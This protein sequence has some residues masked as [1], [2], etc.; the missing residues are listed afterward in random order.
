[1]NKFKYYFVLLIASITI[2]SCNKDKDEPEQVPLRDY[3]VQYAADKD[4]I[5][6][7]LKTNYIKEVTANFDITIEKIP[8]GGT[9][10]SIWEQTTYP[11]QIRKVYNNDVDYEVYYLILNKG[12]GQ[13][14][15]NSDRINASYTGTLLNGTQ[16]DSSYGLGR[17]FELYMNSSQAVIDGWGE[18]FPQFKTGTPNAA[19]PDGTITYKDYGAGVMFLP[20]GLAYYGGGTDNIPAYSPL[21]FSFKLFDLQRLDHDGD[22]V[23]DLNEDIN[24]DGYVYDL[25]NTTKFPTP[26]ATMKDDTDGDGIADFVDTDDDGDGF[27]TY[28]EVTKPTNQVGWVDGVFNG[29]STYYPWDPVADNPNTP[30]TDETEPRGIPRRPTGALANPALPESI[31]NPKSYVPADY[32]AAGR[33]RIHLDKT[34][35]FP[36]K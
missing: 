28:Y 2:I 23:L 7:Y 18:I 3:K 29:L 15:L 14:P 34:Y 4:S 17:S 10:V 11:L 35:P 9:Q 27:S 24:G 25:R 26:P 16:F 21:V 22:G 12:V 30:N 20:S 19:G 13:S 33:L 1:M 5:V 36:R 8:A 6:K 31:T 32:T